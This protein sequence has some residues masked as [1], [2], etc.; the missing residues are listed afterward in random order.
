MNSYPFDRRREDR[1][2]NPDRRALPREG[3]E[4]DDRRR[5]LGR[6]VYD[7]LPTSPR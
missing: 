7:K 3:E 5:M 6:R 1:R 4:S 2:Q